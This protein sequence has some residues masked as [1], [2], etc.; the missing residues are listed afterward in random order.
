MR[1]GLGL[2]TVW[3]N[4]D[5]VAK[6]A[7]AAA[8]LII[9]LRFESAI[10]ISFKLNL[11]NNDLKSQ[12]HLETKKRKIIEIFYQHLMDKSFVDLNWKFVFLIY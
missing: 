10:K 2:F 11:Y 9:S 6:I 5:W 8:L 3:A 12:L 4:T 7:L 1:T